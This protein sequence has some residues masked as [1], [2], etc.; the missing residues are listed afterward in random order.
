MAGSWAR[1]AET[2]PP[3]LAV[4][5]AVDQLRAD[6]LVRF[7]PYF[8]EG[9]FKRLLEGGADFRDAHY[10][11]ALTKTAPGHALILSGVHAN[12]HSVIENEWLDRETWELIN[13]VEDRGSPLVGL[14]PA[15]LG[16]AQ[17][18]APEKTGRSPKNLQA[19]TVADELKRRNGEKSKVFSVSNKDRSAILL[20]GQK[21]DGAYWDEN[22][23]W[24]TSRHYRAELPAWVVAFN[25][26]KRAEAAFGKVWERLLPATVYE[27]VQ[28]PDDAAGE[29]VNDQVH[30]PALRGSQ[31]LLNPSRIL[32][33][34]SQTRAKLRQTPSLVGPSRRTD[35]HRCTPPLCNVQA[36]Q[37]H[38]GRRPLDQHAL[39][40]LQLTVGDQRVMHRIQSHGI[41]RGAHRSPRR[42]R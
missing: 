17:A 29:L 26:E 20:G 32:V 35:D 7:R 2:T 23:K 5:I 39:T 8:G 13:S 18:K 24:V 22:G 25:A 4:V 30:P 12:V 1:A 38:T 31:D 15:E 21:A 9:G 10:R 3:K 40:G 28:G 34:N 19:A 14:N 36:H 6:Y 11:H 42:G 41:A 27:K 37:T 33:V 16:P